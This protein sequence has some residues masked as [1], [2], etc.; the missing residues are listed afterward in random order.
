MLIYCIDGIFFLFQLLIALI[1]HIEFCKDIHSSGVTF[2]FWLLSLISV[3]PICASKIIAVTNNDVSIKSYVLKLTSYV[4]D[5]VIDQIIT[6]SKK[7]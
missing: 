3:S 1:Q 5:H 6:T 7:A 4:N 2:I